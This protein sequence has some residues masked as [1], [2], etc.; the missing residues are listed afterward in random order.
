MP[1]VREMEERADK[2]D[3]AALAALV[4]FSTAEVNLRYGQIPTF[5]RSDA[6]IFA[7]LRR[8][9]EGFSTIEEA[10]FLE[11]RDHRPEILERARKFHAVHE[12]LDALLYYA[13]WIEHWLND[14]ITTLL[15]RRH[16]DEDLLPDVIRDVSLLGK[17][18]WLMPLVGLPRL[19]PALAKGMKEIS[20]ARNAFVH[21][22]YKARDIELRESKEEALFKLVATAEQ[23]VAALTAY[24]SAH[25]AG[26]ARRLALRFLG[27]TE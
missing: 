5:G 24:E 15:R 4:L 1:T 26:E 17:V 10:P 14:S 3:L 21:W 9:L 16:F 12:P 8:F 19:E 13:I 23:I 22:K 7:E 11:V 18:T 27:L 25:I 6:E 20:D 2:G